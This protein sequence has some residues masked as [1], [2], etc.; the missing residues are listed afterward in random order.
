MLRKTCKVILLDARDYEVYTGEVIEP[1]APVPGH[2]PTAKSLP[3]PE[4]WN[5]DWSYKSEKS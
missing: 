5:E 2:I 1:Y 4:I 3:A